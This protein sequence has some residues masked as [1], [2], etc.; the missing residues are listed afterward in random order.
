MDF[1]RTELKS[2]D[3]NGSWTAVANASGVLDRDNE[4]VMP[5]ALVWKTTSIPVHV[6]HRLTV[7]TLVGRGTPYYDAKG[8]LLIDGKFNTS[9]MAQATRRKV[10]DG[11]LDSM[12]IVMHDTK[13][14][15]AADGVM[16]I[17]G[18]ELIACDW[19]TVP[20]N[21]ESRVLSAR[22]YGASMTVADARRFA[23]RTLMQL[24]ELDIAEANRALDRNDAAKGRES[25]DP[26]DLRAALA[27]AKAF[28]ASLA[29]PASTTPKPQAK[30]TTR[31]PGS[32]WDVFNREVR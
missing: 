3:E 28:L 6:D 23:M 16:E 31:Q 32:L 10:L 11:S 4:R 29:A 13:R 19:V 26:T 12:S 15:R 17:V 14:E 2:V 9:E 20:S 1:L 21:Y 8:M 24:A 27:D 7:E 30:A 22:S 25:T 18:G 5:R